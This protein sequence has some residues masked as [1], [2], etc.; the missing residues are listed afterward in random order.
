M[1]A[2]KSDFK[3]LFLN[4]VSKLESPWRYILPVLDNID[5]PTLMDKIGHHSL[6]IAGVT[7]KNHACTF[8]KIAQ[9]VENTDVSHFLLVL[10]GLVLTHTTGDIHPYIKQH[11]RTEWIP[12]ILSVHINREPIFYGACRRSLRLWVEWMTAL[13]EDVSFWR[14]LK[15]RG[16]NGDTALHLAVRH[17]QWEW[18]E[19]LV[20]H[21]VS[22]TIKNKAGETALSLAMPF[23]QCLSYLEIKHRNKEWFDALHH[24]LVVGR[25]DATWCVALIDMGADVNQVELYDAPVDSLAV[26]AKHGMDMNLGPLPQDI[27][28]ESLQLM[29]AHG[30]V[31][32]DWKQVVDSIR[33]E[34]WMRT[35]FSIH[36]EESSNAPDNFIRNVLACQAV[37]SE[38]R[39]LQRRF[40]R[41]QNSGAQCD[42]DIVE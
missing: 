7:V 30:H 33:D 8:E 26:F 11:M 12:W 9:R 18:S 38:T 42:E 36:A 1:S 13:M 16:S 19:W 34:T 17:R 41:L 29:Y 14:P 15:Q 37:S 32:R 10:Y 31:P 22:P 23:H 40:T 39:A 25:E 5:V 2:L 28:R 21:G 6:D 4:A 27:T 3:G 24:A 35:L 20:K